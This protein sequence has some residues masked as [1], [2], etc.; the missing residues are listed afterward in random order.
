MLERTLL[1][2]NG[3]F[4]GSLVGCLY[5]GCGPVNL[6]P[7]WYVDSNGD[8]TSDG[9]LETPFETI[10]RAVDVSSMVILFVLILGLC[11]NY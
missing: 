10:A 7:V 8:N 1:C 11:W 3:G 4:D 9:S 2:L 6:G 5:A